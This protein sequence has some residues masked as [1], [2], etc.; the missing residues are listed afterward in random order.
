[1]STVWQLAIG[2]LS[3]NA[4]MLQKL[5]AFLDPDQIHES[6]LMG[7]VGDESSSDFAFLSDEMK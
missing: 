3:E 4:S 1:M 2:Q 5:L 7:E 6:V